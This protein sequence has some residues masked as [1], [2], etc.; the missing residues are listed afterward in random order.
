MIFSKKRT[1]LTDEELIL[2]YQKDHKTRWVGELFNRY[3]HLVFGVSMKYLKNEQEAKDATLSLFEKLIADLL[4]N[5][6]ESFRKWVYVVSR[7]HCLMILRKRKGINGSMVDIADVSLSEPD[8]EEFENEMLRE[9]QLNELEEALTELKEEQRVCIELFYL[10]QK[11]YE[12]VADQTGFS[13]KQVKSFIQNGKRNLKNL[14]SSKHE[15]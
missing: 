14:L 2:K 5:E 8:S 11:C 1:I 12:Q 6:V 4:H 7:N 13:V 3:A 15:F 9:V 10:Q